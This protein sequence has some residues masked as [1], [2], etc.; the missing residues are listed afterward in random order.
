MRKRLCIM[1]TILSLCAIGGCQTLDAV[2][3][4]LVGRVRQQVRQQAEQ[5]AIQ[6]KTQQ[7][8]QMLR[9]VMRQEIQR[10]FQW[11]MENHLLLR[12]EQP[13]APK[14]IGPIDEKT[15]ELLPIAVLPP[16]HERPQDIPED[17]VK[18]LHN[19]TIKTKT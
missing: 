5:Q 18:E 19:G 15:G 7:I 9:I 10:F 1:G 16:L 12:P 13:P 3:G 8:E 17:I 4:L 11:L 2:G 14:D 6:Q